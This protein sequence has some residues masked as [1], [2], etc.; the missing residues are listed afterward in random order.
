MS[1]AILHEK[2]PAFLF[3]SPTWSLDT[4][5]HENATQNVSIDY[6]EANLEEI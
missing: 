4:G 5:P 6:Y 2:N 1:F 3:G